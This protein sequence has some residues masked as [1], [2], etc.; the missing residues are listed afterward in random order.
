[1]FYYIFLC[2]FWLMTGE[3]P[4]MCQMYIFVGCE[5]I[6]FMINNFQDIPFPS[7]YILSSSIVLFI[8]LFCSERYIVVIIFLFLKFYSTILYWF[9]HTSTWI[10]HEYTRVP[11]PEPS[12]HLPPHTIPLGHP[13]VP[14]PKHPVSCIEPGLAIHF[15]YDIIRFNAILPNHPTLSLSH[16]VQKTVLYLC[17][18]FAVL[19]TGL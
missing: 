10:R 11:H 4:K 16:R 9:C 17:V 14:A 2:N 15:L 12:S 3:Y 18:S 7:S 1:M 6:I 13:S 5:D 19:H 8:Y